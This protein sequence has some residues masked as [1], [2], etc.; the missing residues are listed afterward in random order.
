MDENRQQNTNSRQSSAASIVAGKKEIQPSDTFVKVMHEPQPIQ[1][2]VAARDFKPPKEPVSSEQSQS[3]NQSIPPVPTV[4]TP[5]GVSASQ[6][7][8]DQ[9]VKAREWRNY[10]K[11]ALITLAILMVVFGGYLFV[12]GYFSSMTT[13]TVTNH[14]FTYTFKYYRNA[15]KVTLG[16]G[17]SGYQHGGTILGVDTTDLNSPSVCG[18]IDLQTTQAFTAQLQGV[19]HDVC[20]KDG[21]VFSMFFRELNQNHV[22]VITYSKPQDQSVYPTIKSIISSVKVSQ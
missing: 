3:Y 7:G 12:R 9:R 2:T 4:P 5:Y 18:E 21:R 16:A 13:K 17:G 1:T 10:I 11:P 6:M 19:T 14:G 22:F 20:V 15:S 8:I